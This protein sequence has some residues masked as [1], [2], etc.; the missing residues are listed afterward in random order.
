MALIHLKTYSAM[1]R[2]KTNITVILPTPLA[3]EAKDACLAS[4]NATRRFPVLYL[5]HGTYGD[6]EDYIRFSR[7]ESYA[8][9]YY[10]AVVMMAT[11]NGC[12]RNMPRG[13]AEYY[14]YVTEELPKMMQWM[15][16]I[17]AKREEN[18]L[19]GLSMG[20]SGAF[21]IGMT[22]PDLFSHVACMSANFDGWQAMAA[23]VSDSPWS[24]AFP[25]G[26]QLS[27][28]DDDL[29]HVAQKAVESG[30]QLPELYVCIGRQDFLYQANIDF[31]A[32]MDRIGLKHLYHEQPGIHNWDFWDDELRRILA[33]LPIERRDSKNWF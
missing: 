33:W 10:V 5:L 20:G 15:F 19:C 8:Q 9:E 6:E 18:F 4:Y 29:Y 31:K 23:D 14:D 17:S 32:H 16:P 13:G 1:L 21:K 7:I 2:T 30:A 12:Y 22:R 28:T 24:L 26:S 25:E 27:G 11:E 3:G